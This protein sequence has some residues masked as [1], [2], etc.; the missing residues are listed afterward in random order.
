MLKC[1]IVDDEEMAIKVIASHIAQVKELEI[2]GTYSNAVAAFTALQQQQ[3]DLLFL[4]IQMPG[5]TGL[6]LIQSLTKPPPVILTTAHREFALESYD[7]NVT[8]YLLKPISFERFLKA[9]GKILQRGKPGLGMPYNNT[10]LLT[11]QE[12]FIYIKSDRQFVKVLLDEILYI[13]SIKNHIKIITTRGSH[14]TLM[15]I[16]EIEEKLPMQRFLRIHRSFIVSVSKIEK[17]TYAA[18]TVAKQELPVGELYKADV[19]KRLNQH[20]I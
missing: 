16:S 11:E 18:L 3:A 6:T 4:D 20:L 5:M 9:V 14:F 2:S 8:D 13:E 15:S 19:L 1:I 10:A 17:F 7:L 12:P